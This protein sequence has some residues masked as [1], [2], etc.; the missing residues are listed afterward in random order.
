MIVKITHTH[1]RVHTRGSG[2]GRAGAGGSRLL[3]TPHGDVAAANG[4]DFTM[5]LSPNGG[6]EL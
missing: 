1:A 3:L 6:K 5:L 2:E 4:L